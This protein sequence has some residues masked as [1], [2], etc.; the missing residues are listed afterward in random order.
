MNMTA[1]QRLYKEQ[2]QAPWLDSISREM[3]QSGELQRL[4]TAVGIVGVTSNP[5][6]FAQAITQGSAYTD[7]IRRLRAQG[8]APPE[9]FFEL[10]LQD[11]GD[12]ADLLRPVYEQTGHRDGYISIEVTPDVVDS[13]AGMLA[14][15]RWFQARLARPNVYVKIPAM[16]TGIPAIEQAIFEG[17]P[18][19]ITLIFGLAR[20]AQV[21][22]AYL[23]GLERRLVAGLPLADV[24]SVASFFVSR[25]DTKV[26]PRLAAVL[27]PEGGPPD[28]AR[29][30]A[31]QGQVAIANARVAYAMFQATIASPRWQRLA[32]A[33]A[34]A[35]RP[36]WASTGTK[37]PAYSD[38][39]YVEELIGPQTVNTMPPATIVAFNDHGTVARTVD[40]DPPGARRILEA[41]A[42]VGVSLQQATQE[43]EA[44]GAASF[45][46]SYEQ[47]HQAI[48]TAEGTMVGAGGSK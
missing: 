15:A 48:A 18:I 21:I 14:Q 19:N 34:R 20:Y 7:D 24:W 26:D 1:I 46:R 42:G 41:L 38:V 22:E 9:I 30:A 13:T 25:V 33:G 11:I 39:K 35:Q 27:G 28:A 23:T 45:A 4:I 2:D 16:D 31:L 32:A 43:L 40:R 37:N 5:T 12:A 36:L 10:M 3:I 17:I 47:L 44:E 6:I 29:L 8:L